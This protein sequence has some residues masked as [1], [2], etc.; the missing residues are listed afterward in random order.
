MLPLLLVI[1][2][3]L[4]HAM[5]QADRYNAG[6]NHGYED[7]NPSNSGNGT[8]IDMRP[9]CLDHHTV[10]WCHG[11]SAGYDARGDDSG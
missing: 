8:S 11:Y 4:A 1:T 9:T 6:Y 2:P 10:S 3:T 7:A 5:T